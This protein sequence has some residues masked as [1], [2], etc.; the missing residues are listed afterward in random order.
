MIGLLGAI[1][2][3]FVKEYVGELTDYWMAMLFEREQD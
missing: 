1:F 3:F 2:Y